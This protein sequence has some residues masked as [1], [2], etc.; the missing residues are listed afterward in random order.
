MRGVMKEDRSEI[1]LE[2]HRDI[3]ARVISPAQAAVSMAV[4]ALLSNGKPGD[5]IEVEL[6]SRSRVEIKTFTKNR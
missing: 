1:H 5:K 2:I 4:S 6:R 3:A